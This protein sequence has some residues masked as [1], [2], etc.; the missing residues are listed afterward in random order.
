MQRKKRN[1]RKKVTTGGSCSCL[2]GYLPSHSHAIPHCWRVPQEELDPSTTL[3]TEVL[4]YRQIPSQGL[5]E[6]SKLETEPSV[7]G[8]Y[9]L[10]LQVN[11]GGHD[12]QQSLPLISPRS[13]TFQ[14]LPHSIIDTPF[15]N[16]LIPE[17]WSLNAFISLTFLNPHSKPF[18]VTFKVYLESKYVLLSPHYSSPHHHLLPEYFYL[19]NGLLGNSLNDHQK[20]LS[21]QV[22]PSPGLL[23]TQSLGIV[24]NKLRT[25]LTR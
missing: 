24:Q 21:L 22:S 15:S 23:I 14:I 13:I 7:C 11:S 10:W 25:R 3:L 17:T 12:Q 18:N 9:S 8:N 1:F 19:F 16:L 4:S 6:E 5:E 20:S 2:L